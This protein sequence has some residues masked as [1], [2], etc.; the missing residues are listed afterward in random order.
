M[1]AVNERDTH[2]ISGMTATQ[3]VKSETLINILGYYTCCDPCA[4]LVVQPTQDSAHEFSRRFAATVAVTPALRAL[5]EHKKY[6]SPDNTISHI[7]VPNGAIYFAGANSG[8]LSSRTIRIVLCDEIDKYPLSAG[9]EG[10]PLKLAEERASTYKAVGR[11]KFIRMCSP[12]VEG[13]SL[14]GH[15]YAASDQR[16]CFVACPHCGFRQTL[17]WE[18]PEGGHSGHV[19]WQKDEQGVDLPQTASIVC[20]ECGTAWS[21]A[22]RI[23]ALDELEHADGYG[24]RQTKEFSCCGIEQTPKKWDANGRSLC[25]ECGKRSPYFGHAGFHLSKLYSKRHRLSDIV[26]E[27]LAAEGSPEAKRKWRNTALAELWKPEYDQ[28]FSPSKLMARCEPYG[29]NGLLPATKVITAGADVHPDRI[30]VQIIAWGDDEES[31]VVTYIVLHGDPGQ[32]QIWAELD[33]VRAMEFKVRGRPGVMK[34]AGL[35]IDAGGSHTQ[36]VLRYA[37]E[38][39]GYVFACRGIAG[40]HA[41]IWPGKYSESKVTGRHDRFYQIAVDMAKQEIYGRLAYEPPEPGVPKAGFVHFP[42]APEINAEYFAQL[43]AERPVRYKRIG[44]YKTIWTKIRPRNEALDTFVLALAIR[45]GG[46]RN[47]KRPMMFK[48]NPALAAFNKSMPVQEQREPT[49][50]EN[51]QMLEQMIA[52]KPSLLQ[53]E[54]VQKLLQQIRDEGHVVKLPTPL[55]ENVPRVLAAPEVEPEQPTKAW[56]IDADRLEGDD[57]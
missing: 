46:R 31:W 48:P 21:E 34:I 30:E 55:P 52:N 3:F 28:A 25:S 39:R 44:G 54:Q 40:D 36:D 23:A 4:A 24:W 18:N 1:A 42:I 14:I 16:Q 57:Q 49:D 7:T 53:D 19:E 9:V 27:L 56:K 47:I 11:A 10:S 37:N 41:H 51:L 5:V 2:T 50:A 43:N 38:R 13:S 15:E 6:K 22:D 32:P 35:A 29:P 8:D 20:C 45:K 12:T 26:E 17:R 33:A